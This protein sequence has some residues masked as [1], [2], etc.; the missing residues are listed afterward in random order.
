MTKGYRN[1]R[2]EVNVRRSI[3]GINSH[4]YDFTVHTHGKKLVASG[5]GV[6]TFSADDIVAQLCKRIDDEL[7]SKAPWQGSVDLSLTQQGKR[8]K[9]V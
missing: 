7:K 2:I 5:R 4:N 3:P 1:H 8:A 9:L 6:T